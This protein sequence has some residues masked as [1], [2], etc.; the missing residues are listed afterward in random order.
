MSVGQ[1]QLDRR[2][3]ETPEMAFVRYYEKNPEIW[4]ATK[5]LQGLP[6]EATHRGNHKHEI[7]KS[8]VKDAFAALKTKGEEIRKADPK[9]TK[10]QA[11][12]KAMELHPSPRRTIAKS[13]CVSFRR[14]GFTCWATP[15]CPRSETFATGARQGGK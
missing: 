1:A 15:G 13:A 2:D 4:Q 7:A 10:E 6:V 5:R 14:R 3:G 8:D 9:L 11:F 12:V